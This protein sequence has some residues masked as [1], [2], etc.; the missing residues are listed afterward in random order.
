MAKSRDRQMAA[1]PT[2]VVLT[3]FVDVVTGIYDL[4]VVVT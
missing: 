3:V 4:N 2:Q 1:C